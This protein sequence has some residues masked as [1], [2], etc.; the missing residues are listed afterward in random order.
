MPMRFGG[1]WVNCY[2]DRTLISTEYLN[3][4]DIRIAQKERA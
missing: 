2:G 1:K 4:A 3:I